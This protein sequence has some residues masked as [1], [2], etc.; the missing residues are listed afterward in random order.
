MAVVGKTP[1]F[2][3]GTSLFGLE[4]WKIGSFKKNGKTYVYLP[5]VPAFVYQ[6][7]KA[8]A[9]HTKAGEITYSSVFPNKNGKEI[10]KDMKELAKLFVFN[11]KLKRGLVN[12][13]EYPHNEELPPFSYQRIGTSLLIANPFY[14]LFCEQGTGKTRMTIDALNALFQKGEIS[15]VIVAT[16]NSVI[17]SWV[18]DL[19]KFCVV[20]YR[21]FPAIAKKRQAIRDWLEAPRDALNI[22]IIGYDF[23]WRLF[24]N[25]RTGKDIE[26]YRET[27]EKEL[28]SLLRACKK[29]YRS[30]E[31]R[32]KLK[33]K[34]L[35]KIL[36]EP[37]RSK[38]AVLQDTLLMLDILDEVDVAIADESQ[39]I[40]TNSAKR[41]KAF[42]ITAFNAKRKY[43]LTGT[44]I[45]N[46]PID[47]F[48]Q[49]KFLQF[50][51]I[52]TLT[53]FK[54]YF[55]NF[56]DKGKYEIV[57]GLKK[58]KEEEFKRF[59]NGFSF[60]VK[61]QDVL[62]DLPEKMFI[63]REVVLSEKASNV[64]KALETEMAAE[65]SVAVKLEEEA[66]EISEEEKE[67][68]KEIQK[69]L[70]TTAAHILTKIIRLNQL[71]SG[72]IVDDDE[73]EPYQIDKAKI[74]A[75]LELLEELGD[76]KVIIWG[77]YK[78]EIHTL[79][80]AI[81]KAGYKAAYITGEVP[82]KKRKE[83]LAEFQDGDLQVLIANPATLS[84]GV[85]LTATDV[86]IY[87]SLT[88]KL[89]DFLQSQDRIHR[90][91]QKSKCVTYYILLSRL[92]PKV[93]P[94]ES[95][96]TRTIDRKIYK[97]LQNKERIANDVVKFAKEYLESED[98]KSLEHYLKS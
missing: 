11:E 42:L 84:T 15:K 83:I 80:K 70:I 74:E 62:K 68:K 86:A 35:E 79:Y 34:L 49:A 9:V 43:I 45:T 66:K 3:Y 18:S 12:P 10:V 78:Y 53:K 22:L 56:T 23:L 60:I 19:K 4:D 25:F 39:R 1:L 92:H 73:S 52:P 46:S 51:M 95:E 20:P 26:T 59:L 13:L 71:T 85:T 82:V 89:E 27:D 47:I 67:K 54:T 93:E 48:S 31:Y 77:N 88:Y 30:R 6:F 36:K 37:S 63:T 38:K 69:Q 90:I 50:F 91:G 21:V 16:P 40:K 28:Q 75:V 32:Q 5:K 57:K 81:K 87:Y 41:T 7:A 55:V 64:Y 96:Q 76:K 61:K 8:V 44:P 72:F 2:Y 14:A 94:R 17:Y 33:E 98:E 97:A 58:E 24:P 65:V 29:A